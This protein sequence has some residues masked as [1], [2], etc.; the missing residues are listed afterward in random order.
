MSDTYQAIFDGVRSRIN[1]CN[2][3]AAIEQGLREAFGM[4]GH[5]LACVA[6]QFSASAAAQSLPSVLYR[7]AISI[8]GDQWC[9]LYGSNLQDGVV[10]FGASVAEAMADFDTQWQRRLPARIE[11]KQP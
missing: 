2:T 11:G 9:A 1:P 3:D 5:Y 7:P 10:G 8:D 6:E 4:T